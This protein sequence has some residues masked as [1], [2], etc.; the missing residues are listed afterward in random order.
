MFFFCSCP[1]HS[2]VHLLCLSRS[3]LLSRPPHCTP[4]HAL[5]AGHIVSTHS[6]ILAPSDDRYKSAATAPYANVQMKMNSM[7]WGT[8]GCTLPACI[9]LFG[10]MMLKP[11]FWAHLHISAPEQQEIFRCV[12]S[13]YVRTCFIGKG[14][15]VCGLEKATEWSDKIL[16]L[17]IGQSG[18]LFTPVVCFKVTFCVKWDWRSLSHMLDRT[19]LAWTLPLMSSMM[20]EYQTGCTGHL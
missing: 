17:G 9:H 5:R 12:N 8:P 1:Q 2:A 10:G 3:W 11:A 20:M 16:A 7:H 6:L 4:R 15:E 18:P 19:R 13:P 14:T